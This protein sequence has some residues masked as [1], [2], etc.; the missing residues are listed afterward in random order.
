MRALALAAVFALAVGGCGGDEG[1]PPPPVTVAPTPLPPP[2]PPVSNS[3]LKTIAEASLAA[4]IREDHP[5]G[6][7]QTSNPGAPST[8]SPAKRPGNGFTQ[9]IPG[10]DIEQTAVY[11]IGSVTGESGGFDIF[12]AANPADSRP[13]NGLVTAFYAGVNGRSVDA[14]GDRFILGDHRTAYYL[15]RTGN[16][17]N[18]FARIMQIETARSGNQIVLHGTASNYTMV[19]T[20][21]PDAGT[22]IF[23]DNAGTWDMIG[24]IDQL[25]RTDSNDP[26]FVYTSALP[27]PST[28]AR[29]ATQTDQFGGAGADLIT[30]IEVDAPGNLYVTG[31][32]RNNLTG[33]FSSSTGSG[34]MFVAKYS[35]SGARLWMTQFGSA[36][37]RGD[38]AWDLAVDGSSVYVAARYISPE[39]DANSFKDAAYYKLSANS[40]A[41]EKLETWADIQVQYAGTVA[42]DN[43]EFVYFGGIGFDRAQ[44]NPDN[45]QDPYI[46]KRN[47]S[48]LSLVKRKLYGGDTNNVPGAG[49]AANKEPWGGLKFVPKAGGAPGQGTIYA[50]GWT[51]QSYEGTAAQGGGDAWV[52]AFDQDLNI[53]WFEGWGSNQRDWPWDLDTDANGF[54]YVTGLTLGGMSGA[55]NGQADGFVTKLDPSKPLGQRVVWTR[56]IGT[57][58]SDELR[59]IKVVGNA[60]YVS[61]HTYG[62][63]PN[64]A[65]AGESDLWVAKLDLNGNI[66]KQYQVGTAQDDRAM[67]T[68]DTNGV[69]VG[70]YTFGSLVKTTFGYIDAFVMKLGIDL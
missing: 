64:F 62:S 14:P 8:T 15:G 61:G 66:L 25:V 16:V 49:N 5:H 59:K 2:P 37:G 1:A 42:L 32:T 23:Y 69:Y 65:N 41:I 10:D 46:E 48:D 33:L 34:Q 39:S 70:G 13:G 11:S 60:I 45:S 58:R 7:D 22:A 36:D 63:L 27:A 29:L 68:A 55:S 38:L 67:L 47:R 50:S 19:Q 4:N 21:G 9:G 54:L 6:T 3:D 44:A 28:V 53:L 18:D 56:Q 17:D 35:A 51:M 20:T 31:I 26:I 43:S 24:Y 12:N 57:N 30:A 40:G 52:V